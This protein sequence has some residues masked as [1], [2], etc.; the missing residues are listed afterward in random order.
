MAPDWRP[1][2]RIK[3]PGLMKL[4]HYRGGRCALESDECEPLTLSLHHAY[5]RSQGGDDLEAN[6]IFLCGNGVTGHHGKV[7][8]RERETLDA[9]R[10]F[11]LKNRPDTL[12][13]L[14]EKLG[15]HTEATEWILRYL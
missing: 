13:Y 5:P 3:D 11:L 14:A 1:R 8:F 15:G 2:R 6:L 10:A 12:E 4:L 9:L 7:T